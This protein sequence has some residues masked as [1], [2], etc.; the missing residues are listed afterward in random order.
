[1]LKIKY[2]SALI[3]IVLMSSCKTFYLTEKSTFSV[4]KNDFILTSGI[5][6]G[7]NYS[8]DMIKTNDSTLIE[9]WTIEPKS[10]TNLLFFFPANTN[11]L[12]V[13][14]EFL[15]EVSK[16]TNSKI[17]G[18]HYR[19]YGKSSGTPSFETSF[20]DNECVFSQKSKHFHEYKN[21]MVMGISVGT[22]F[23]GKLVSSHNQE[24]DNL[25]LLSTFSSPQ[26]MLSEGMRIHVPFYA[27]PFIRIRAESKLLQ[28][29][30]VEFLK[31]YHN[32]LLI[33]QAK[34]DKETGYQMGEELFKAVPA[35]IKKMLTIEKG[36]HFAPISKEYT[37]AVI[38]EMLKM[39]L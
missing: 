9:T 6:N 16:Q 31:N 38:D 34:D 8:V 37:Q 7:L 5:E 20:I 10:P 26:K 1:M 32:N 3:L 17:I 23:S 35:K 25:I 13:F 27:K 30:N 24:I 33:V 12:F 36:G 4:P 14:K 28:L 15:E 29:N 11:N 2:I 39:G 19:G 22:L 18:I 21:I